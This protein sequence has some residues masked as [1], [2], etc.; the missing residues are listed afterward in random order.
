M[1]T[2][3][4]GI[5]T[6]GLH[7]AQA[8]LA[9]TSH[10]IANVHT[11]A[12]S[13]QQAVQ[14]TPLPA[15]TGSGFFGAGV[16]VATVRR[17][18][19]EFLEVELRAS[20]ARSAAAREL[21]TQLRAL[22][23]LLADPAAG[24]APALGEFFAAANAVAAHPADAASRQAML[25]A[26]GALAARFQALDARF[27]A[28]REAIGR[29]LGD[30][31]AAV[32]A[33][34]SRIADLNQRILYASAQGGATRAPNDL[35][36]Q[37][38]ALLREL[39]REVGARALAQSDGTVNVFLSGG[40]ALV[41][42]TR[43][44]A[45]AT[46]RDPESPQDFV[47]GIRTGD[48]LLRLR[49]DDLAGGRIEGLLQARDVAL[50]HARNAL[51]RIAIALA[52]R[53]ND[54]HRLGQDL[55]GQLG[56]AF[57]SAGAPALTASSLNTG[58]AELA[59][60]I[61]D[62]SALGTSPYRMRWDG[63]S[64]NLTRLSDGTTRSFAMLPQ[65]V[66][67]L[68]ISLSGGSPQPGDAFRIEPSAAGAAGFSVLVREPA[69]IAAA[70]PIRTGSAATNSGGARISAGTVNG[71]DPNLRE[72]VTITFTGPNTYDVTGTGTG[73]P[74]G[75]SYTPGEPISFNGWTVTITGTPAA[76]DT[77]TVRANTGGVAD[78]RNALALAALQTARVLEGGTASLGEAYSMLVGAVGSHTREAI[79]ASEAFER[80]ADEA[81]R[82]QQELS[83]V[84]LDEEAANLLRYQQAYQASGKALAVAQRLFET[85]LELGGR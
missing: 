11:A 16:S 63:T 32:N 73:N 31:V 53:F 27:E 75:L 68:T 79:L 43:A 59:V 37:R 47:V 56:A 81:V 20:L 55:E 54:Q 58:S 38:D 50:A 12:F 51:G 4:F 65:T 82:A 34:A 18:Y 9:T 33:Y 35:L 85:L 3:I 6:S 8:G 26:A 48:S 17:V 14:S 77:F 30:A 72:T 2:S 62:P 41:V 49:A 74:T 21:R 84:N 45:L 61:A 70:A 67:G 83:G 25:S 76:G 71:L 52:A 28:Q 69:R 5:A 13:R 1:A 19:S 29:Q 66:D 57:F 42:G 46:A 15:Y 40:Q 39:N 78:N 23:D 22:D 7:A 80:L 44:Y 36:D 24:L 10:N 64:W 60:S